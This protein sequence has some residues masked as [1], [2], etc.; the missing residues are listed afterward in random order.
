MIKAAYYAMI[1]LIDIQFGR[2]MAVLE[3]TGEIENTIVI[4]TSD[5][6]EMLGDH[7]IYLKGPYFYE[8]MSHVPL[9]MSWKGHFM[10]GARLDTLTELTD[11]VPTIEEFCLGRI[12]EGV[13]G[14]S[15]ADVLTA[16]R[17]GYAPGIVYIVN[18]MKQCPGIHS[19]RH[20]EQ[21]FSMGDISCHVSIRQGKESCMI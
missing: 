11:I 7:G 12:E 13:Q 17:A 21:W 20:M 9:I 1:E 3:E 16:V 10:E 14:R 4:F 15:L 5:H 6:G 8:G 18:I 19:R 2:L